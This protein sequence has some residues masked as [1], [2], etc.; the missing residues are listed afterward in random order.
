MYSVSRSVGFQDHPRVGGEKISTTSWP[1]CWKGSP[2]RGRG[3]V[4]RRLAPTEIVRITPA[5]AGKS[6]R[7]PFC[8]VRGRD[9]PRVGGEKPDTALQL[10]SHWGSPPRGRGKGEGKT[11][12]ARTLRITPAW[13]GKRHTLK[14]SSRDDWDH[15]RVGGE[16]FTRVED[17]SSCAGSPPRGR[18]K[19]QAFRVRPVGRGITPAWAGKSTAV[20]V[21][22]TA[23]KDHPRVGGEKGSSR[24]KS[25]SSRG[26]PPRG[27][28][29][30]LD[31]DTRS[32]T[33]GITPAWAGKSR[34]TAHRGS[35]RVDHP[36]VGGEKFDNPKIDNSQLG[37]P[38]RGRGKVFFGRM[39]L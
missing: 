2:P 5:W 33:R 32:R 18:G 4:S 10:P 15:P 14:T 34:A 25:G 16:K 9:H 1:R 35:S 3:K 36:R 23:I 8:Y 6:E 37:S 19:A 13:A 39:E 11:E 21:L 22:T 38:P 24:R 29:K 20:D 31:D 12:I 27:R 28:G 26:S 30:A 17:S 7:P